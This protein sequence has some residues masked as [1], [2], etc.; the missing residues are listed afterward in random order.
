MK[1]VALVPARAG[2]KGFPDKN[3]ARIKGKTLIELAVKVGLDCPCIDDV[4]I[5]TDSLD[6]E[7]I[8]LQSGARSL[9][10]RPAHLATDT[11]K[12]VDTVI[13]FLNM[14]SH[15]YDYIV[16]LQP[17]SPMRCPDDIT[18]MLS[19][20]KKSN[21]DAIVSVQKL[22]EPHPAKLKTISKNGFI[23][24][25]MKNT[26]SEISRQLLPEVYQLNGA[27]YISKCST[28]LSKKTLLPSNTL[29]YAMSNSINID[30]QFDYHILVGLLET[31]KIFIHGV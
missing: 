2:S 30:S 7:N 27:V 18:T 5:S 23:T 28:V 17:T 25:F 13:D 4:Y 29:P 21:A 3:I 15:T 20:L 11:A 19:T 14:T 26:T 10:L 12:T 9:G 1:T 22:E 6:Y 24:S 16:L 8:A 31:E